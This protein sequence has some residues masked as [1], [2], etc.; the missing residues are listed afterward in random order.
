MLKHARRGVRLVQMGDLVIKHGLGSLLDFVGVAPRVFHRSPQEDTNERALPLAYRVRLLL[1]D[2]GPTFIKLGQIAS[3]R[4][5]LLS[6]DFIR[7]LR[8]LQDQVEPI[9]YEMVEAV[10][11]EELGKPVDELFAVFDPVPVAT[12]SIG[13]V[14][15][16][17]MKD[18][19]QVAVKVQRPGVAAIIRDD[20]DILKWAA[21]RLESRLELARKMNVTGLLEEFEDLLLDEL[22]YTIEG[23]NADRMRTNLA[24]NPRIRIPEIIWDLTSRRVLTLEDVTGIKM[25]NTDAL[26]AAGINLKELAAALGE[27][28]IKQIL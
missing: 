3:T 16:A 4:Q 5:D 8:K 2:L 24:A 20:M 7:E 27:G 14:H 12:A 23:R 26:L 22:V 17:R 9:P 25:T 21:R 19:Q 11:V 13:Q 15:L 28:Y 1:Q 10:I 6:D 18:G